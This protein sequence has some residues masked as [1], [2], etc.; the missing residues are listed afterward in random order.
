MILVLQTYIVQCQ[1]AE[2]WEEVSEL[3]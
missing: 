3:I 1:F 2:G